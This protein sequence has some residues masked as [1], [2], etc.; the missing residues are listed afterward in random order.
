MGSGTVSRSSTSEGRLASRARASAVVARERAISAPAGLGG[1]AL[2]E[3]RRRR[4]LADVSHERR[5]PL[6]VVQGNLEAMDDGVH[7][8]DEDHLL[9]ILDETKVLSR[10][11]EDLRTL[12]L[13]ESGALALHREP[14]DLGALA[15]ETLASFAGRAEASGVTLDATTPPDLPLA[16]TDPVRAREILENLVA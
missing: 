16:D 15:R 5:T 13:A 10:L 8:P 1:R 11:I 14:T 6:A 9:A 7:P 12:S 2:G 4:L 3:A